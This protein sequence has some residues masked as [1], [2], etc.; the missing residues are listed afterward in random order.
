[1]QLQFN[2]K[3]LLSIG[4]RVFYRGLFSEEFHN[5]AKK[6]LMLKKHQDFHKKAATYSPTYVVPSALAG[7]TALFGMERGEPRRYNHLNF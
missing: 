6:I 2:Y 1:M 4:I 5:R 3:K 7:L